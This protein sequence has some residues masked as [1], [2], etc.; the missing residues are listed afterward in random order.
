MHKQI[1]TELVR[2]RDR[3]ISR[4]INTHMYFLAV[5]YCMCSSAQNIETQAVRGTWHLGLGDKILREV[6]DLRMYLT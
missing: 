2:D 3:E 5:P 6:T 1:D 4:R